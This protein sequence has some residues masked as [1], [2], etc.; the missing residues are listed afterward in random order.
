M[1]FGSNYHP[2]HTRTSRAA[3]AVV[4]TEQLAAAESVLEHAVTQKNLTHAIVKQA[5]V[6]AEEAV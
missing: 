4:F 2:D 3:G 1:T 5:Q 6:F